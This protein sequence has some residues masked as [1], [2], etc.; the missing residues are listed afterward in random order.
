MSEDITLFTIPIPG[1]NDNE[2][3]EFFYVELYNPRSV[4]ANVKLVQD[5]QVQETIKAQIIIKDS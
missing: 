4:Y 3:M 1:Q 5:Q 2:P